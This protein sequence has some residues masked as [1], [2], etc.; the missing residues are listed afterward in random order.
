MGQVERIRMV[1][2]DDGCRLWTATTGRGEP[3]VCCHGGPGLWDMLGD[4]AGLVG[5]VATVHR[6]DQRGCGRSDPNG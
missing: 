6:W 3:L 4:L 1:P 5:D 2:A